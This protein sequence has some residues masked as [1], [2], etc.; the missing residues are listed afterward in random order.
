M[1]IKVNLREK[2]ECL[3]WNIIDTLFASDVIRAKRQ[4]L[5]AGNPVSDKHVLS[6]VLNTAVLQFGET[7][8]P[9]MC[10]HCA[11]PTCAS[12][13]PVG[14]IEKTRTGAVV[15]SADKCMGCR[16]VCRHVHSMFR[17]TNGT[18]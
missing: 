2:K 15:Y 13:C 12:V 8:V 3:L 4:M 7:N 18:A 5:N 11:E 1:K 9:R 10:M 17:N 6:S 14:A 16:I